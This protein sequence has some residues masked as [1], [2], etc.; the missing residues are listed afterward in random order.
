MNRN[1]NQSE[2]NST[3]T[4]IEAIDTPSDETHD[5]R[6]ALRRIGKYSAYAIPALLALTSTAAA[7]SG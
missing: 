3:P 4:Q 1:N 6:S 2:S 5:R 7:T